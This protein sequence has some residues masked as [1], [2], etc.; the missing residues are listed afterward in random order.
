MKAFFFTGTDTGVGKTIITGAIAKVLSSLGKNVGVMKPIES[1]CTIRNGGKIPNDALFLKNMAS[2][3]EEIKTICPYPLSKPLAP[4]IAA[5][6]E[7]IR[8]D[9]KQIKNLFIKIAKNSDI[10]LVEGAGGIMVPITKTHLILDLVKLLNIPLIIIAKTVLGTI[11]H[12]LLTIKQAQQNGIEVKGVILNKLSP[13]G[14][15]S[16]K[17]N[18]LLIENFSA[19][20]ILGQIPYIQK[21]EREKPD[22]LSNFIKTNINL[23]MFM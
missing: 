10:V 22:I 3:K 17:T 21:V 8:V 5:S 7:N 9:L 6:F 23:S 19:V 4:A 2:C 20:P 13:L 15:E 12:T 1:G 18:P 11:N 14:D 16:E